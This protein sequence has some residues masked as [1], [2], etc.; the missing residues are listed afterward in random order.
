MTLQRL[1][2][3]VLILSFQATAFSKP[4]PRAK[5]KNK[6]SSALEEEEAAKPKVDKSTSSYARGTKNIG[7]AG[8]VGY[9]TGLLDYG[10][11]AFWQIKKELS[12]GG[13]FLLG[14]E[15]LNKTN[16]GLVSKGG[17]SSYQFSAQSRFYVMNNFAINGGLAYRMISATV[18]VE[19][20]FDSSNFVTAGFDANS[21]ALNASIGNHWTWTNGFT[22]G[23]DWIGW[24]QVISSS[25][26]TNVSGGGFASSATSDA[27][28][29]VEIIAKEVSQ[30]SLLQLLM[31]SVGFMF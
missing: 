11:E 7:I 6:D 12:V 17:I 23:C 28:P 14:S 15:S 3:A 22:V 16:A 25:Y 10:A 19:D 20:Q 4:N 31:V 30:A 1:T 27:L 18:T 24:Q 29:M 21:I 8:R 5:P 2:I 13:M 9:F 26:S